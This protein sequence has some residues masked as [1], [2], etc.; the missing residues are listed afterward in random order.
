MSEPVAWPECREFY[1]LMQAYRHASLWDQA[2]TV[3]KYEAVKEWLRAEIE[4]KDA[5]IAELTEALKRDVIDETRNA[6]LNNAKDAAIAELVGALKGL[7]GWQV[8]NVNAWHN[9]PYDNAA[10]LVKKYDIPRAES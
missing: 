5:A 2:E 4:R 7:M 10:G 8:K 9:R 1:E 6:E 3:E